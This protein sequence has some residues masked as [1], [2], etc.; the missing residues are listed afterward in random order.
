[1]EELAEPASVK[2]VSMKWGLITGIVS[3]LFFILI[4]ITETDTSPGVTWLGLIPFIILVVLAHKE[5]KTSGDGYM[6]YSQGLGIGT[7][8][9]LVS[10]VVSGI[11]RYIWVKF[12]DDGYNDRIQEAQIRAMEEQGLGEDQ[13]EQAL[14][15]S[16]GFTSPEIVLVIG[17]FVGVLFG[18]ILSLIISA[19]TKNS[20]PSAEV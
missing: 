11:F 6:S 19:F 7:L 4:T 1:M 9:S 3:I 20:D 12:L 18:F 13:I 15:I 10:G 17:L 14:E 8:I 2:K 5:F 16:S